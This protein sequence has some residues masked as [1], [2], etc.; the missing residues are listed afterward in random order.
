MA[1]VVEGVVGV[2]GERVLVWVVVLVPVGRVRID[3]LEAV[4]GVE[5]VEA[6]LGVGK[7]WTAR[8]G[9]V[10]GGHLEWFGVCARAVGPRGLQ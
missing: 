4:V 5:A 10:G 8:R 9:Q 3:E 2:S 7:N 1:G 6:V